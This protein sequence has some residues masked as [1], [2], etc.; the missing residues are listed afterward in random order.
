MVSDL[1][2]LQTHLNS[3]WEKPLGDFTKLLYEDRNVAL[4][5]KYNLSLT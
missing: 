5:A 1:W 3:L 2:T 4:S